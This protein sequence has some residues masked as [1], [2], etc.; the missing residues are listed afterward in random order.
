M[1]EIISNFLPRQIRGSVGQ[2]RNIVAISFTFQV[3]V[4]FNLREMTIKKKCESFL[5]N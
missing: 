5:T 3:I 4:L 1:I 2:L